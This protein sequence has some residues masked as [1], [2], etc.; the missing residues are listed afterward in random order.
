MNNLEKIEIHRRAKLNENSEVIEKLVFVNRVAKVVKGGRRFSFSALVVIGDG[1]GSVGFGLGKAA[2]VPDAI[3]K[4]GQRAKKSM[5][6]IPTMGSS[7]PH[8]VYGKF[9]PTTVMLRPAAPGTGL[10]A[11][12]AVRAIMEASGIKDIRTKIIGSSNPGQVLEAT[13]RGLLML[14][15]PKAFANSL[16]KTLDDLGF[17]S[18]AA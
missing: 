2:E 15:D 11:G 16:G 8:E 5:I 9:G 1:K 4:A 6:R 10:I 13:L 7:I 18:V 17:Q 3:A 12:S 14:K